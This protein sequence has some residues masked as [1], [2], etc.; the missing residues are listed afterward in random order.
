MGRNLAKRLMAVFAAVATAFVLTKPLQAAEPGGGMPKPPADFERLGQCLP[1]GIVNK[2]LTDGHWNA[3]ASAQSKNGPS[4]FLFSD[5]KGEH[6][7]LLQQADPAGQGLC[8]AG[9]GTD[10]HT[11]LPGGRR[12]KVSFED[13]SARE[14]FEAY[15]AGDGMPADPIGSPHG[16]GGSVCAASATEAMDDINWKQE[17]TPVFTGVVEGLG[18]IVLMAAQKGTWTLVLI[19][20]KTGGACIM[21]QGGQFN[22]A[23]D[24]KP[25]AII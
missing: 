13:Q 8:L 7:R 24:Y 1:T 12:Y 21:D 4:I 15:I 23:K 16:M 14:A 18:K 9:E 11:A 19:N 17:E 25:K 22:F 5:A 20:D 3:V 6:W 10:M 2:A